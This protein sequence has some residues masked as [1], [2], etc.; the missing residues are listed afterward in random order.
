[1]VWK[2]YNLLTLFLAHKCLSYQAK[3]RILYYIRF[4]SKN[5]C[6]LFPSKFF[7]NKN[8]LAYCVYTCEHTCIGLHTRGVV[9]EG[10][11]VC[12]KKSLKQQIRLVFF[13][14]ESLQINLFSIS[15]DVMINDKTSTVGEGNYTDAWIIRCVH[16]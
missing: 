15:L 6:Y 12:Y 11:C 4:R 16:Y 7:K 13:R 10:M 14:D 8:Y 9:Y 5:T 1:M 2:E 3:T